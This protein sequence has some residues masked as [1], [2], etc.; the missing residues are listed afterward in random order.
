MATPQFDGDSGAKAFGWLS[1]AGMAIK[2]FLDRNNLAKRIDRMESKLDN[3]T[4]KVDNLDGY[5]RGKLGD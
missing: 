4:E 5:I 1:V 2:G 3:T